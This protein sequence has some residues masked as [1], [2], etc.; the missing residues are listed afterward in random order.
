MI[1]QDAAD[2]RDENRRLI[3]EIESLRGDRLRE[4]HRRRAETGYQQHNNGV[5]S[6]FHRDRSN[7]AYAMAAPHVDRNEFQQQPES[8]QG[9][10]TQVV[11]PLCQLEFPDM[12][13]FNIHANDCIQ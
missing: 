6:N 2:L 13:T 4:L 11:C 5:P 1:F 9:G 7:V 3:D 10:T 8:L 12:D